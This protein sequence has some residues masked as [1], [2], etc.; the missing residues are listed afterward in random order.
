MV[1]S[2]RRRNPP[3]DGDAFKYNPPNGGP[4]VYQRRKV[5]KIAPMRCWRM[6]CKALSASLDAAMASGV[7][8]VDLVQPPFVE[9]AGG[10]R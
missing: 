10:Y 2:L 4:A 9:E 3:E 5:V 8:A 6:A 1:L 7:K